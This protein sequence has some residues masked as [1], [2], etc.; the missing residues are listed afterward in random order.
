MNGMKFGKEASCWQEAFPVGNGKIGGMVYGGTTLGKIALNEETLWS[1]YP[2]ETQL[3]LPEGYLQKVK[4]L[5]DR[6]K[7]GQAMDEIEKYFEASEDCQM[8]VPFGNLYLDMGETYTEVEEYQRILDLNR[9]I[10][11]ITYKRDGAWW[12]QEIFC[13]APH[14]VLVWNIECSVPFS[15]ELY[16]GGGYLT[17]CFCEKG[18]LKAIG[19]CPG[20]N[21]F[22]VSEGTSSKARPFFSTKPEEKGM[23][24]M[25]LAVINIPEQKKKPTKRGIRIE[26]VQKAT[27]YFTAASS[28]AGFKKHPYLAGQAPQKMVVSCMERI[29]HFQYQELREVHIKDYAHL[30]QR[31]S[32]KFPDSEKDQWDMER[33]LELFQK[34]P[35]DLGL[36]SLIFNFGRYLMISCSRPG[37]QPANGQGIWNKEKIP[38]WN[39]YYTVNINTEMNYWMNGPCNLSELDEPLIRMNQELKDDGQRTAKA[40]FQAEG[41]AC[42]S[43]VDLWRKTSFASGKA[44]WA[45]WPYGAAWMARNLF[46]HY[47][48]TQD[49][50]ELRET[51]YPLLKENVLFCVSSMEKVGN[52]YVLSPATSPENEFLWEERKVSVAKYTENTLAI[53]RN[54]FRDF[55]ECCEILKIEDNLCRQV[56][57]ILLEMQEPQI[58]SQ[59][60]ILE[61]NEEFEEADIKHRHLSHLYELYPGRGISLSTPQLFQAARISLLRRGDDGSGWS[62]AWKA[63]MWARLH[64]G[65]HAGKMIN[66]MLHLSQEKD[67]ISVCGGGVYPNLLCAHPPFQID[68][69]FGVTAA[70][71]E[72]LL[73]SHLDKIEILPAVPFTWT[74]GVVKGLMA[75]GRVRTE[76]EWDLD[77][78]RVA[79]LAEENKEVLLELPNGVQEKIYLPANQTVERRYRKRN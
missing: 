15:A 71:A 7:Y 31:V 51:I 78:I 53:A 3:T 42:G 69:N 77:W 2:K 40:Y 35:E 1:G 26:R 79:L 6:R 57:E 76:I 70:I 23:S 60:Q 27:I 9:A 16:M 12:K 18:A 54:L 11:E 21:P 72:M 38:P 24:Y 20:R 19:Q 36:I 25:G 33:R 55:L 64:D 75:R 30:F 68:G 13:S 37:T 74:R 62:I 4:D 29:K 46:E 32:L 66:R 56:S 43:N 67:Q 61:W 22:T 65:E 52:T 45:F 28:F 8:Y 59:G 41:I 14:N 58:G 50:E 49:K 44:M 47:N 73:Q 39:S 48:F 34:N 10:V 63:L 17:D 5:V